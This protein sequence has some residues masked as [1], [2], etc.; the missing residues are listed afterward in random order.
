M[1]KQRR[2][3][4]IIF[5]A[6]V[7]FLAVYRLADYPTTW[8]D[9]GSHLHVPK[10]LLRYGVYADYSSD[11]FRYFGPTLG[12]GPTVMLPIAAAFKLFGVGLVQARLVIVAYLLGALFLFYRL[13]RTLE[14]ETVAWVALAMLISSRSI[15]LLDTG[16]QVLGEVPALCFLLGAFIVWFSA[17]DGRRS[18]L[19]IAGML[20]GAAVITKYQLL[21]GI[22]P[23]FAIGFIVNL[24]YYRSTAARVFVWPALVTGIIFAAWQ[25]V[26]VVY[27]GPQNSLQNFAALRAATAGAAAVFSLP[28][29]KRAAGELVSFK[30][31]GGSLAIG[32]LYGACL[33]MPRSRTAQQRSVLLLFVVTTTA[34]YVFASVSWLRYAFAGLAVATLFL[35]RFFVDL[36]QF[37]RTASRHEA[38]AELPG[39]EY[40]R[41]SLIA[42][43]GLWIAFIVIPPLALTARAILVPRPNTPALMAA[44]LSGKVPTTAVIETWEPELGFLTAHNY[45]YPPT[46]MLNVAVRHIWSGGPAP[47]QQYHPLESEQP[48]Y[49]VVGSFARWVD[50]YPADVLER[51]YR[52]VT[53][54]G[55]YDLYARNVILSVDRRGP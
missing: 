37:L 46:G 3:I 44:Y 53:S 17:W 28:L 34:W 25:A 8:F 13:A 21:L 51:D 5:A 41:G 27:L 29:M 12:V 2:A 33:S 23:T 49:V 43:V 47:R 19:L 30:T 20:F 9:E 54:I 48:P 42:V 1:N 32:L 18:R 36:I 6:A 22:A 14:S 15:A 38:E 40:I 24:V 31:F 55:E 10:A 26:L 4:G 35:A 7:A 39:T 52:H 45:H 11:G 50:V 16:R